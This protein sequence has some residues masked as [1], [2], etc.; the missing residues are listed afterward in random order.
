MDPESQ[1]AF[2]RRSQTI[3]TATLFS[4]IFNRNNRGVILITVIELPEGKTA[5][6]SHV[7]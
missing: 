3:Y 4:C 5:G 1:Q 6:T 2:P 7:H